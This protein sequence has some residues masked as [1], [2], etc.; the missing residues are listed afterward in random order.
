MSITAT[1]FRWAV[2]GPGSI[3]RRFATQLPDSQDGVLVAVGS[4]SPDRART[5]A[6]EFSL[7]EPALLGTYEEVLAS[8]EVDAVYVS[9]VHTGHARLAAAALEA[10]KHVLCEKPLTPNSG[11][12][13][14]LTDLAAGS[15]S[16]LLEAYMYRFH[17]Q[18]ERV[19]QLV[20]EGAI[21][22]VT[23]VDASFAFDTGGRSGRLFDTATAGGGILD[24]GCYPMSFARF[25]AGA[26]R[27]EAF[28]DPTSIHGSGTIGETGVDEWASAELTLPGNIT[29]TL[30]TGVRLA[31]PQSATITGSRGVIRLSDPWGLGEQQTIELDVVGQ[32]PQRIAVAAASAYALEADALARAA[33][34]DGIVPEMTGENSLGQARALDLWREQIGLR[35]PFERDDAD[36]PTLTGRPLEAGSVRS[37][38]AMAYGT[39]AGLDKKVSRLVMGCDNQMNLAHAT[40]M[41]DAFYEIGGTTFD[42]AYI[43]GGGYTEKLFGQWVRNCG[44]REDVVV[45]AKGAH[46]PH[47]DPDSITRQLEESLERQGT[48]YADLY[49]MHRDNPEIPVGEFVDVMD[50]HLRAGRI[51]AYGGSNWT[52]QRVDEAN[53]YA[54]ANGRTGFTILSNH[55]GL[56]EALDVPWA[57]CVHATDPESKAWLEERGIALL[58]WSSQARGFFTGRA[59]PEDRS[60]AELVRCYYS[61]ENFERLAR[62]RALGQEH[63]VPATAIALAFVLHQ[64]FPTFALFG[65][66]SIAEMRS[67]TLGLGVELSE[68]DLAWLDLKAETR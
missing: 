21:G 34:G 55:F 2:L 13:M 25:V 57:G 39:L 62:A 47:C 40:A 6:Q 19:L 32:Q 23:H 11:T 44:V 37:G 30:R 29:A 38:P 61:E 42:T 9:T 15:G 48:D 7:A 53:A 60:D 26:A 65:P 63:G 66:R 14:A 24:V 27:G 18:T 5:F 59:H 46:T 17:P 43:Y 16:V 31:D 33:R 41:Y 22:E 51:R 20:A 1:P 36:I 68:R 4:S 28:A 45:I 56:A 12:T 8:D 35:Y 52:P 67:S 10:G 58:P 50:E 3:A 64:K 54:R 49:M